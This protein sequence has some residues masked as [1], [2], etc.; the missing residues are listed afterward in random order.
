[1]NGKENLDQKK[2]ILE[3]Y[4]NNNK[5]GLSIREFRSIIEESNLSDIY[6]NRFSKYSIKDLD[7]I[8]IEYNLSCNL[9]KKISN[10]LPQK[11]YLLSIF[12]DNKFTGKCKIGISSNVK[13]R[14]KT[15]NKAW[16]E[17]G[18]IFYI[19]M[20]TEY[21]TEAL[22]LELRLHLKYEKHRYCPKSKR[23]GHTEIFIF[24]EE[25]EL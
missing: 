20:Q 17:D 9:N 4:R 24:N 22:E 18:L 7:K 8:C 16:K 19:Y 10:V 1:M 13:E 25:M 2:A 6:T 23:D 15:L 21:T 12:K 11:V 3:L 5:L 14:I